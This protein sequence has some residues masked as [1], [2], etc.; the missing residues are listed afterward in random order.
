MQVNA[1][2][3][4]RRAALTLTSEGYTATSPSPGLYYGIKGIHAAYIVCKPGPAETFWAT[5]FV[6]SNTTDGNLPGHETQNLEKRMTG[7][8]SASNATACSA[9]NMLGPWNWI[10]GLRITFNPD[11]TVEDSEGGKGTWKNTG[12]STYQ[13]HWLTYAQQTVTFT[14]AKDGKSTTGGYQLTRKC[15]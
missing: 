8:A 15:T 10:G 5:I 13:V 1:A 11:G 9:A 12:G 7:V 2:E 6:G 3:C 14:L 4:E